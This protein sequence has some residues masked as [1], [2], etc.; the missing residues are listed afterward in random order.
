MLLSFEDEA[1]RETL[2]REALERRVEILEEENRIFVGGRTDELQKKARQM[3][4]RSKC[5][6]A[7]AA[8]RDDFLCGLLVRAG[9]AP[10]EARCVG[11]RSL[12]CGCSDGP[13][14]SQRAR[15]RCLRPSARTSAAARDPRRR[16]SHKRSL[17]EHLEV[18]Q[19]EVKRLE[20]RLRDL[21]QVKNEVDYV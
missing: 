9:M 7:A 17:I 6:I 11:G 4:K 12:P 13:A 2:R 16:G 8:Q 15:M 14:A 18:Q 3:L 10:R 5:S 20:E 19:A 1:S 21:G